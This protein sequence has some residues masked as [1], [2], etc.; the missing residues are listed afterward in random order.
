[1]STSPLELDPYVIP[2]IRGERLLD[3]GCGYGHW[4]HLARTHYAETHPMP[5]SITGVDLFEG[6]VAFCRNLGVYDEVAVADVVEYVSGLP[7]ASFDT[8]IAL[9]LIE[10]LTRE[11]GAKLLSEIE[12]VARKVAIL[13]TPNF[14][15]LRGGGNTKLGFNEWEHHLSQWTPQDFSQRGFEVMGVSH[16]LHKVMPGGWRIF[17]ASRALNAMARAAAESWPRI[18][19]NLLA[20]KHYDD[21]PMKFTFGLG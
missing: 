6:N 11:D 5:V 8:V 21:Q 9:E 2:L 13:S 17:S 7:S 1:M 19:L 4:G 20:V 14:P 16:K 3:L 18:S 15:A 12:R 10:H